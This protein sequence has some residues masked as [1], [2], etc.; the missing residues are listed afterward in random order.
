VFAHVDECLLDD[1]QHLCLLSGREGGQTG[2]GRHVDTQSRAI[3]EV[4]G[5]L[6]HQLAQR[7]GRMRA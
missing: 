1:A 7:L 5:K 3:A 6:R 4:F 2:I